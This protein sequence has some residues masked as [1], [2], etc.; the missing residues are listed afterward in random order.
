MPTHHFPPADVIEPYALAKPIKLPQGIL[1]HSITLLTPLG[2]QTTAE[3]QNEGAKLELSTIFR[4]LP[5]DLSA[6]T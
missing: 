3:R 4:P 2:R 6:V 5:A 1:S